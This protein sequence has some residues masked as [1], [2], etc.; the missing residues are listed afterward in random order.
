MYPATV[1]LPDE[2]SEPYAAFALHLYDEIEEPA[3]VFHAAT[4]EVGCT[5]DEVMAMGGT[6]HQVVEFLATIATTDEDGAAP[7]FAYGIEQLL[8]QHMQQVISALRWAIVDALA[9][10]CGACGEFGNGK[11]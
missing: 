5:S 4:D 3:M 10:R 9:L 7:R 6:A 11:I 2:L 1:V 8:Y